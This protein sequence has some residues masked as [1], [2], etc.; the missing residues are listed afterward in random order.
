MP[1]G[2]CNFCLIFIVKLEFYSIETFT[3]W[4]MFISWTLNCL[5]LFWNDE[6][7]VIVFPHFKKFHDPAYNLYNFVSIQSMQCNEMK[8]KGMIFT[9]GTP[10][11]CMAMVWINIMHTQHVLTN[12][13]WL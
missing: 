10:A 5:L 12:K 3:Q 13:W 9:I 6:F 2:N 11:F 4:F 1:F 7:C 8:C